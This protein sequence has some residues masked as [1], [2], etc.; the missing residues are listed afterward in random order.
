MPC[1]KRWKVYETLPRPFDAL[2][3]MFYRPIFEFDEKAVVFI[4]GKA[5]CRTDISLHPSNVH[6]LVK[7]RKTPHLS[8]RAKQSHNSTDFQEI[9]TALRA[10]Q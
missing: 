7:G 9:A 3:Q 2:D 6:D 4:D 8:L 1:G 10:S 5:S